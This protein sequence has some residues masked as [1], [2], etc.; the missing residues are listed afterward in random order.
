MGQEKKPRR[1]R[2]EKVAIRRKTSHEPSPGPS[3][4]RF[5]PLLPPPLASMRVL[6]CRRYRS[7]LLTP[8]LMA[9]SPHSSGGLSLQQGCSA[10]AS[11]SLTAAVLA[12]TSMEEAKKSWGRGDSL[13]VDL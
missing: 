10:L 4:S 7:L 8:N 12:M 5:L 6:L 9:P 3:T 1:V 2:K 13:V 11:A